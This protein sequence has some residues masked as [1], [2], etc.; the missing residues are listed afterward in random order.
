[1]K[2]KYRTIPMKPLKYMEMP[3]EKILSIQKL[4]HRKRNTTL[5]ELKLVYETKRAGKQSTSQ[6]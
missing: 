2:E 5:T 3:A 6:H 1:M 4:N